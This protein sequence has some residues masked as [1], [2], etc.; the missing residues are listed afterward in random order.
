MGSNGASRESGAAPRLDLHVSPRPSSL[1]AVRRSLEALAIPP[2]LMDD[3]KLLVTELVGNSIKHSS[4]E[5]DE[6]IR[7]IAEWTG[8][9]L[10]V[11]VRDRPRT[12]SPPSVA[13]TIRPAAGAE[14][15]W[16]LFIVDRIA[17]RWGTDE[18]GYW[19][20]L[21]RPRKTHR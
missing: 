13:A 15:G 16:G 18:M 10:R 2:E 20:E 19:F 4:R 11:S 1:A 9:R 3:A 6:E 5:G 14:S 21:D 17:S 12:H 8:T 7:I